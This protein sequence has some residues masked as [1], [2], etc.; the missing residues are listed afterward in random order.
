MKARGDFRRER[1]MYLAL[2][3]LEI[4]EKEPVRALKLYN[5][6][7][8]EAVALRESWWILFFDYLRLQI[9]TGPLGDLADGLKI[10][11]AGVAEADK[12]LYARFPQR[13][14]LHED[15]IRIQC[16]IDP[17]GFAPQI[18]DGIDFMT[19][20]L[21]ADSLCH[22][23]LRGVKIRY[24]LEI[25]RWDDARKLLLESLAGPTGGMNP[26]TPKNERHMV[27]QKV[28]TEKIRAA[29]Y[30]QLCVVAWNCDEP[31]NL[32][33]WA[34]EGEATG[35]R[36]EEYACIAECLMWQAVLARREGDAAAA[37]R[38]CH[39]AI[40]ENKQS[41]WIAGTSYF[42][43]LCTFYEESGDLRLACQARA[44]QLNLLRGKGQT[45]V[46]VR[47]HTERCRLLSRLGHS[48]ESALPAARDAANFLID[49][50]PALEAIERIARGEKHC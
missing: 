48:L 20:S 43:A 6:G 41:L 24:A 38:L 45:F 19:R 36:V 23:C 22:D 15:V 46:E 16:G 8:D 25:G 33:A 29:E 31:E 13:V 40:Q 18:E 10:A 3:A 34:L 26:V 35:R 32:R 7:R 39:R 9:I 30:T 27:G 14:C 47:A 1:L 2:E 12:P 42:D 50:S 44:H 28:T 4:R 11:M 37:Q 17:L 21:P 49:P 5:Q